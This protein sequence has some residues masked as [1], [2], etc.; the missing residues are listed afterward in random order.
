MS[1]FLLPH[2]DKWKWGGEV[3]LDR[4]KLETEVPADAFCFFPRCGLFSSFDLL[5]ENRSRRCPVAGHRSVCHPGSS[6]DIPSE[7]E[8]KQNRCKIEAYSVPARP[9]LGQTSEPMVSEGRH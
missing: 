1:V 5:A 8:G 6:S 4:F 9:K 3:F 7:G 2:F